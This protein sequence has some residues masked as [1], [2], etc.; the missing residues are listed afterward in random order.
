MN[1]HSIVCQKVPVSLVLLSLQVLPCPLVKTSPCLRRC[2]SAICHLPPMP[3][4]FLVHHYPLALGCPARG[5]SLGLSTHYSVGRNGF[6][7]GL[8]RAVSVCVCVCVWYSGKRAD[9]VIAGR[10]TSFNFNAGNFQMD[11]TPTQQRQRRLVHLLCSLLLQICPC[12]E[13]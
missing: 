12:Q 1:H 9:F 8:I 2:K 11:H 6:D 10:R 5:T 13:Q 3:T 4:A 7:T